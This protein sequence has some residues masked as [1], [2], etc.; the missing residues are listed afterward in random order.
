MMRSPISPSPIAPI[1]SGV[2]IGPGATEFAV[3]P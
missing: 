3:M 2:S 1:N